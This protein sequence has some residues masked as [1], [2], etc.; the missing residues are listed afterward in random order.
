MIFFVDRSLGRRK[1]PEALRSAGRDVVVHDDLFD[2][3]TPDRVWLD[4][5]GREG[6]V[7]LAKDDRIR[8]EPEERRALLDTGVR[9]FVLTN[10]SLTGAEQAALF[11]QRLDA[12]ERYA[13][14]HAGPYIVG[15]YLT[16]PHLRRL[17]PRA[18]GGG[19]R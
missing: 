11:R 8:Y 16:A 15:V 1:V 10:A 13:G 5:A 12:I 4:R 3:D 6:W 2:V 19:R 9:A 7:V 18:R 17:Y 14:E